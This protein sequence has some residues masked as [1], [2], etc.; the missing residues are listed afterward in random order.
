M[1]RIDA[2][3]RLMIEQRASDLHFTAGNPPILRINGDLVPLR[4]RRIG[5]ADCMN[6]INEIIPSHLKD[7]FEQEFD[8][9]FSYEIEGKARFRINLYRHRDGIGSTIR[10]IPMVIPTIDDLHLPTDILKFSEFNKGLILI[11]GPTGSGKSTTLATIIQR[12]NHTQRRHILTIEDPIEFIYHRDKSLI[13]QREISTHTDSFHTALLA[14][15]RSSADVILVGELRD[16]ETISLALTAAETGSLVFGT[17]HTQSCAQA[18][19]RVIDMFPLDK[20]PQI[21]NLLSSALKGVISQTLIK[22]ADS[23]GRVPVME[24]AFGSPALS[25]LIRDNKVHQ[26]ASYI[27]STRYGVDNMSRDNSLLDLLRKKLITIEQAMEL[28]KDKSKFK[29]TSAD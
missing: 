15:T 2:F 25:I 26:I 23:M 5:S 12:I 14:A 18:M 7:K 1:S 10:M 16:P 19:T 21:R 20:Q 17:L 13:S 22:R 3:L 27:E 11:T 6:F 29:K 9:D 8:V 4:Y 28:A 24:I